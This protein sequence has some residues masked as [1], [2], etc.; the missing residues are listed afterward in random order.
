MELAKQHNFDFLYGG[1]G[2]SLRVFRPTERRDEN[3]DIK[4]IIC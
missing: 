2:L 4:L 3:E 1:S